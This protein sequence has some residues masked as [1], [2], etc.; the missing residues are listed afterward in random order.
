MRLQRKPG[1][2]SLSEHVVP[3]PALA[4]ILLL[5]MI[6]GS[7]DTIGFFALGGLFTAHV[8]GNVVLLSGHLA[9]GGKVGIAQLIS[10]PVFMI[11]VA[12]ARLLARSFSAPA[13]AL[14]TLQ[15]CFLTCFLILCIAGRPFTDFDQW[16][17][18]LAGM[19][20]IAAMA[21]QN[22]LVQSI[23][24]MPSTA[25]VTVDITRFSMAAIDLVQKRGDERRSSLR[26]VRSAGP[27]IAGFV[28]GCCLGAALHVHVGGWALTLPVLLATAVLAL[29]LYR[30]VGMVRQ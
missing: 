16:T 11:V 22:V 5:S 2:Q 15:L 3:P 4:M 17:A 27:A 21:T 29:H 25:M 12:L 20:G 18:V 7:T 28:A 19:S 9:M 8:T 1:V 13:T 23:P 6:A 10:V 30:G 26:T 24:E 14:M